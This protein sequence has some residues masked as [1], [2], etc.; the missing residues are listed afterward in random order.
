MGAEVH[1]PIVSADQQKPEMGS[2]RRESRASTDQHGAQRTQGRSGRLRRAGYDTGVTRT[3]ATTNWSNVRTVFLDRDGVLNRKAPEGEYVARWEDFEILDG[4]IG[5]LGRLHRAGL[6]TIVVTN[7]RG[8][9]LGRYTTADVEALHARFQESL[10]AAGARLDAIFVCPHN[11][12]AC[13]CRKPLPGLFEQAAAQF[14]GIAAARSVMIGDSLVD[15]EFGKRL[16]MPTI[17]IED[18]DENRGPE[19]KAAGVMADLRCSS[20]RE[21]VS[22]ILG[23]R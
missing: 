23:G 4:V 3:R 14:P 10:R 13:N 16:G 17:L 21:A 22:A 11:H 20:L 15:M 18:P 6:R 7:Q 9:A 2:A 12:G 1:P 5:A 19:E 8:V